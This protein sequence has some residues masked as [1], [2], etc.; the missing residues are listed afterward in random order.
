LSEQK[1]ATECESWLKRVH[2]VQTSRMTPEMRETMRVKVERSRMAEQSRRKCKAAKSHCVRSKA[3]MTEGLRQ[4]SEARAPEEFSMVHSRWSEAQNASEKRQEVAL[5]KVAAME[6]I[7]EAVVMNAADEEEEEQGGLEEVA[8][9]IGAPT[10][11]ALVLVPGGSSG[12]EDEFQKLLQQLRIEPTDDTEMA[13]KFGLYETYG[14]QVEKMRATLFG[15]YDE[16][17]E[18]LPGAVRK[19][20]QMQLEKVD[21]AEAMGIYDEAREWFVYQ[22]MKKAGQ[23][24]TNMSTIMDGFEKR[25]EFLAA[26]DQDECPVCLEKFSESLPAETLGCCHKVCNDCWA[27]WCTVTHGH[28]FCPLCKNEAFIEE[29]HR[30][31]SD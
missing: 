20:L 8:A 18:T 1:S 9:L 6:N 29:L 15:L 14:T 25:L 12:N 16:N 11:S 3:L 2:S 10:S 24:N 28:P 27:H 13:A 31:A 4:M 21:S 23:N 22:M 26:N 7:E 5:S 19:D 17:K 30:R